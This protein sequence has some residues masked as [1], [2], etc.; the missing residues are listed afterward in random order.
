MKKNG[1]LAPKVFKLAQKSLSGQ[2]QITIE[3]KHPFRKISTRV[4]YSGKHFLEIQING[5]KMKKVAFELKV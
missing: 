4:Y 1:E 5:V 3:K 2:E